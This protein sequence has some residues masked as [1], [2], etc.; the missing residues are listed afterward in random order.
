[1][2]RVNPRTMGA[3]AAMLV[4]GTIM[5]AYLGLEAPAGR[6]GMTD[7]EVAELLLAE[8]ENSDLVILASI[9]VGVG[10]LL[11]LISLGTARGE[12]GV[13]AREVKKPAA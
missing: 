5:V 6:Q 12:G 2:I 10:F 13:R 7:D 4:A 11:V 3:G 1:V 8:R 9:L